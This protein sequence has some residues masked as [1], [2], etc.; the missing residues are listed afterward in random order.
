MSEYKRVG[1]ASDGIRFMVNPA[2]ENILL[3]DEFIQILKE[4]KAGKMKRFINKHHNIFKDDV[5]IAF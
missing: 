4:D 2:P 3:K 5:T 1:I